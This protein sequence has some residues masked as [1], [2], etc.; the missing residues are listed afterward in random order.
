MSATS[1]DTVSDSTVHLRDPS[2]LL[3]EEVLLE[4]F[5][6]CI[7]GEYFRVIPSENEAPLHLAHVSRRWR[8]FA[9][10]FPSLWTSITIY[11][12]QC[13]KESHG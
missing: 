12:V 6:L 8:H 3:Q 11:R 7:P 13:I 10:S 9:R 2:V 4:I 5:K 1:E